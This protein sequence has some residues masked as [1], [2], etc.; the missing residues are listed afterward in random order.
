MIKR[1]IS[2]ARLYP[3]N[4]LKDRIFGESTKCFSNPTEWRD[5]NGNLLAYV[6]YE[7]AKL[8]INRK[9]GDLVMSNEGNV[10]SLAATWEVCA[11]LIPGTPMSEYTRQS[12]TGRRRLHRRH[13]RDRQSRMKRDLR[14]GT[15]FRRPR[16][17][18]R[19]RS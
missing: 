5:S 2:W 3:F 11:G 8:I 13:R 18:V 17:P 19:T 6:L 4:N 9:Q 10:K 12:P 16:P 14:H 1:L 7:P 15:R